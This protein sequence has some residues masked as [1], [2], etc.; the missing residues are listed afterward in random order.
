MYNWVDLCP[1]IQ[2]Y[3]Y[4]VHSVWV[5]YFND[6][7][8]VLL[9]QPTLYHLTGSHYTAGQNQLWRTPFELTK[10]MKTLISVS[11]KYNYT[12]HTPSSGL[13]TIP[14]CQTAVCPADGS[15]Y[16]IIKLWLTR[17]DWVLRVSR[18]IINFTYNSCGSQVCIGTV[19]REAMTESEN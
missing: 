17:S 15:L 3:S 5:Y 2:S 7:V 8:Y 10:G 12:N 1:I 16:C 6:Q 18:S 19:R 4:K 9:V 11:Q 13:N 14:C